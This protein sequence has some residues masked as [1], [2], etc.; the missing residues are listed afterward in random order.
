MNLDNPYTPPS[1]DSQ[2]SSDYNNL[3]NRYINDAQEN[4]NSG[5]AHSPYFSDDDFIQGRELTMEDLEGTSSSYP[6]D[7][8]TH[9]ILPTPPGVIKADWAQRS[10]PPLPNYDKQF[11]DVNS[12]G[13][14]PLIMESTSIKDYLDEDTKDNIAIL[15]NGKVYL[16]S[17]SVI[18][19]QE[20][21]ALV[22]ECLEGDKKTF[23]N[24]VGNLPF[25]NIKKIGLDLSSDNA[26]GIEA[27]YIYIDGIDSLMEDDGQLFSILPLVDKQLVS[28][29]S[30]DESQNVGTA[31]GTGLSALHCQ[32][33]QGGLAGIIVKAYPASTGGK[34]RKKNKKSVKKNKNK[35]TVKKNK[36][37]KTVKKRK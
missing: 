33:G 3:W 26:V 18:E 36:K 6:S 22:Y 7:M 35:K 29:I 14:N 13:Y 10:M 24:I 17:R 27:E 12:S 4:H 5:E 11:I 37:N 19:Q 23:Q 21:D 28:V 31:N 32:A 20:N 15:Y 16:S 25:Y 1:N 30:Y 9:G 8:H 2:Y 34:R